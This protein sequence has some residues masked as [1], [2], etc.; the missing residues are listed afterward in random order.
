MKTKKYP[1][2]TEITIVFCCRPKDMKSSFILKISRVIKPAIKAQRIERRAMLRCEMAS[3]PDLECSSIKALF[4]LPTARQPPSCSLVVRRDVFRTGRLVVTC[5][6]GTRL[7]GTR[8]DGFGSFSDWSVRSA[9]I[10]S[11]RCSVGPGST[12]VATI[13][14]SWEGGGALVNMSVD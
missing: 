10:E 1:A 4:F 2:Y 6:A 11:V 13:M 12:K 14:S 8:L 7:D 9:S 3:L 5:F